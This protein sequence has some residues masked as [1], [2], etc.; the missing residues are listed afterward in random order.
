MSRTVTIMQGFCR[1]SISFSRWGVIDIS[2]Y[3]A[4]A[5]GLGPGD[6]V[7]ILSDGEEYYLTRKENPE[8]ASR[9]EAVCCRSNR[10]GGH[11]R[12]Y[13]ARLCRL[14]LEACGSESNKVY[15]RTGEKVE[16]D[17]RACLAVITHP[18]KSR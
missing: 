14:M 7:D 18:I 10:S 4:R 11:L 6:S 2:A 8:G 17:G 16:I 12:A 15:L 5:V 3:A 9:Y 1:T 13:S